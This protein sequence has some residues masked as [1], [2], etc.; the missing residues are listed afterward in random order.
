MS[1]PHRDYELLAELIACALDMDLSEDVGQRL[2]DAARRSGVELAGEARRLA[3]RQPGR[4]RLIEV[5]LDILRWHRFDPHSSH[6]G[7][8]LCSCPFQAVARAHRS[9]VCPVNRAL[10]EG[11]V[12]G[13]ELK[14][15][16]VLCE[17]GGDGCCVTLRFD[18]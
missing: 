1:L 9:V 2:T 4:R 8:A 17:P 11:L 5:G 12:E 14:G 10:M 13:L 16:A 18:P 6:R 3:G 7:V 15:V